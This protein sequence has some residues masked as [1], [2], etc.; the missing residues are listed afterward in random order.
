MLS[1]HRA[2]TSRVMRLWFAPSLGYLPVQAQRSKDGKVEFS[3]M[4]KSLQR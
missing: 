2:G 4:I 3:M 1:S